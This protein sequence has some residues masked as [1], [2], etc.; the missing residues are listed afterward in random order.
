MQS[1]L[2][3]SY[4]PCFL[5]VFLYSLHIFYAPYFLYLSHFPYYS[6][7]FYFMWISD[8][9][10]IFYERNFAAV[11]TYRKS[12]ALLAQKQLIIPPICQKNLLDWYHFGH[13]HIFTTSLPTK[14][15]YFYILS[16]Y[17]GHRDIF[18]LYMS[19]SPI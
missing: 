7:I 8:E 6:P 19:K 18:F 10:C 13:I 11:W 3:F 16:S 9:F 2:A 4:F 17:F 1:M 5:P 15:S 12:T 14:T